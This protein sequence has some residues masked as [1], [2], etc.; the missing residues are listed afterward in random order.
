MP[1]SISSQVLLAPLVIAVTTVAFMLLVSKNRGEAREG[2]KLGYKPDAAQSLSM[3]LAR[4]VGG[5]PAVAAPLASPF[6]LL[7][8]RHLVLYARR[9]GAL[10]FEIPWPTID[11]VTV[12][13][14]PQMEAAAV[15]VRGLAPG[16]LDGASPDGRFLRV[17]FEDER[18][19]WQNVV[20]EL[21]PPHD[22]EQAREV[23]AFWER[24]REAPAA[25]TGA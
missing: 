15:A 2:A 13:D 6:V 24:H 8:D 7:T 12:L 19:W 3:T 10:V 17:R 14:R 11:Q 22:D 18:G 20:F 5:H 23:T 16:A 25:E 9:G 21:A 1:T 4:Y